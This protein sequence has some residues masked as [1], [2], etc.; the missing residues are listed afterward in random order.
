MVYRS[1]EWPNGQND[2]AFLPALIKVIEGGAG[3]VGLVAG[4]RVGR[5]DTAFKKLQSRIANGVR[6]SILRDGTRDTG[7]GL[8]AFLREAFL[9]MPYFDGLHRFLPAEQQELP[10]QVRRPMRGL[11]DRI[12]KIEL[13]QRK[14]GLRFE[15]SDLQPDHRQD[16]IEIVRDTAR[17][18]AKCLHLLR[19]A[20]LFFQSFLGRDIAEKSEQ[21]RGLTAQLDERARLF[22]R[23][24][25]SIGQGEPAFDSLR[26]DPGF[27]D[28]LRR[29][30]L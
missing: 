23:D 16:V 7:C 24:N 14:A 21:K 13:L 20:E 17:Q 2:P 15:Q 4:Q 25:F 8:K 10:R 3:R 18:L 26:V 28:L 29:I 1:Y 30:G 12:G 6:G 22:E 11:F 27:K 19:L 9:L 5:K